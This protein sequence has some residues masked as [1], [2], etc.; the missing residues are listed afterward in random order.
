MKEDHSTLCALLRSWR[1]PR[2]EASAEF[3]DCVWSRIRRESA[4]SVRLL[5]LS[6]RAAAC[7]AAAISAFGGSAAAYAYESITREERMAAEHAR[8]IDPVQI[9]AASNTVHRH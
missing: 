8:A 5:G 2:T 3:N 1:L 4:P 7:W 6:L 9:I